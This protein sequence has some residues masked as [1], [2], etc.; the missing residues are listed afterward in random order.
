MSVVEKKDEIAEQVSDKIEVPKTSSRGRPKKE[1]KTETETKPKGRPKTDRPLTERR[2]IYDLK[3][4]LKKLNTSDEDIVLIIDYI[5]KLNSERVMKRVQA[6]RE[7]E[8]LKA[9]KKE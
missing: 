3:F 4:S 5:N 9:E 8:K 1:K 6:E 7:A 2:K